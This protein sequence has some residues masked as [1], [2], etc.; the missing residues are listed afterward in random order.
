MSIK[1]QA[2]AAFAGMCTIFADAVVPVVVTFGDGETWETR[3]LRQTATHG[4][5]TSDGQFV[6]DAACVLHLLPH[7]EIEAS[8]LQG[9]KVE[10]ITGEDT[11]DKLR[12]LSVAELPSGAIWRLVCGSEVRST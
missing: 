4:M 8:E 9:A 11:S 10:A 3:A 2:Q 1:S 12:V 7:A 6:E 5:Q